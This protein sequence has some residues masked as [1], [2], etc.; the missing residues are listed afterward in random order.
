MKTK[1]KSTKGPVSTEKAGQ[2]ILAA[3]EIQ[4]EGSW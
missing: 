4:I 2:V 3:R 1:Q